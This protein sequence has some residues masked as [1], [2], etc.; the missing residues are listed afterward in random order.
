VLDAVLL[1]HFLLQAG[2]IAFAATLFFVLY[3]LGS[4]VDVP[5]AAE[6]LLLRIATG[7]AIFQFVLR[8]A[9]ELPLLTP[10]GTLALV[11][12]L[13]VIGA[14]RLPLPSLGVPVEWRTIAILLLLVAPLGMALAPAVSKDALI[15]HL[16]FPEQTLAEGRWSYDPANS[17]SFY[18]SATSTLY[19]ATLALDRSGSTAQLVHLGFFILSI[20]AVA[21]VARRLGAATGL[22]A[23][24]LFAAVP[25][26]GIVAGWSWSDLSLVFVLATAVLALFGRQ[27]ALALLLL[28]LSAAIK[29]NA[30]LA[31][32]PLVLAAL[33]A[34]LRARAWRSLAIGVLLGLA[35]MAPWYLTNALRTGNP[36]YPLLSAAHGATEAVGTWSNEAGA[37]WGAIWSGYFLRPQTL[38]EDIG[39]LLFLIVAVVGLAAS[40]QRF[41]AVVAVAMWLVFLP[42][43]P[44]LR[45]LL[46][47]VAAVLV[48]AG[49][50]L[51]GRR[52]AAALVLAFAI[53]GGI[54]VAAHNA[55]FLNPFPAAAGIEDG[56]AYVARN[57]EPAPLF[58]RAAASLPPNA[59]VVAVNEVRLFRF[60]RP[61]RAARVFDPPLLARY[62]SGATSEE[63]VLGRFRRDG[64]THLLLAAKPVERGTPPRLG[65]E[66]E[67]LFTAVLRRSRIVERE[68]NTL[69]VALEQRTIPSSH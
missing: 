60:P 65:A 40:R 69:L 45:L 24:L 12:L 50:A 30:L 17:A 43:T 4:R 26:A 34:I 57:F 68:G 47:A 22:S 38:D 1:G 39:G 56:D 23:A 31:A 9:G 5:D 59:R 27:H 11:V 46:P 36:I 35:A 54:V 18:P 2:R 66:A 13:G 14:Y 42:F 51:E 8:W 62:L 7:F 49:A 33:L 20:A 37:S 28:G 41:A 53:R 19:L 61:V 32:I 10:F 63:E 3:G 58:A 67:R 21:A 6:R 52:L 16:R 64:V 55:Q 48:V 25:T 44:A 15:Y 29:Y